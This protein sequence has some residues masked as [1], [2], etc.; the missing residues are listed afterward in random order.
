MYLIVFMSLNFGDLFLFLRELYKIV[1][2]SFIK[3]DYKSFKFPLKNLINTEVYK[4][5][6]QSS[7][8][9]IFN[10]SHRRHYW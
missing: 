7:S 10:Y 3:I 8:L 2:A 5:K 4:E 1:K 6:S 9:I